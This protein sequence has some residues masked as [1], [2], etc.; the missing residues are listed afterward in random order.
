LELICG[1]LVNVTFTLTRPE[2]V[3][4][5]PKLQV[6]LFAET[7]LNEAQ[8]SCKIPPAR[9]TTLV[10]S[11]MFKKPKPVTVTA[12]MLGFTGTSAEPELTTGVTQAT[13]LM[14]EATPLTVTVAHKSVEYWKVPAGTVQTKE[15]FA[16]LMEP[17]VQATL[18]T[19]GYDGM[20]IEAVSPDT[21][22]VPVIVMVFAL[23]S[24]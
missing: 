10:A 7:L 16:A 15:V 8:L 6:K 18:G 20:E 3:K 1:L 4:A 2:V 22:P 5:V 9:T 14:F 17:T 13:C 24:T 19:V 11:A 23:A 12:V 21:R